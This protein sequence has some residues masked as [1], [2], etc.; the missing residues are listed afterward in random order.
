M[1]VVLHDLNTAGRYCDQL[2]L[3]YRGLGC[4]ASAPPGT[5]SHEILEPVSGVRVRVLDD[6]DAVQLVFSRVPADRS[7]RY[8][9]A[10]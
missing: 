6:G 10:G 7:R 5:C 3:L 8:E 9:P 4:I 1:I 2:V